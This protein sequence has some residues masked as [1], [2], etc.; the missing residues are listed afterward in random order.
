MFTVIKYSTSYIIL[1]YLIM[2]SISW[3]L[4]FNYHRYYTTLHCIQTLSNQENSAKYMF[5]IFLKFLI[6]PTVF[7]ILF[8]IIFMISYNN[9]ITTIIWWILF[10]IIITMNISSN[11]YC[12]IKASGIIIKQYNE[13]HTGL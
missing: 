6:Y 13:I 5:K 11:V 8:S 10:L 7:I 12:I 3:E 2:I 9:T 1:I 4:F